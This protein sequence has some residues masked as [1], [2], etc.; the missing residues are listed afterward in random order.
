AQFQKRLKNFCRN[1]DFSY[2][3][4]SYS[5][6]DLYQDTCLKVFK[7]RSTLVAPGNILGERDFW[8][9]LFIVTR[10]QYYNRVR[11]LNRP[12]KSGWSRCDKSVEEL[13]APAAEVD[14][15]K[16]HFLHRFLDFI[17]GYP[18]QRQHA[19]RMWLEGH[20]YRE[21]AAKLDSN[22][23]RSHVTVRS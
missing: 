21:I 10:N 16:Q 15:D 14:Y 3:A 12:Q 5:A 17:R 8:R 1:H 18:K 20:S 19:I 23:R 6:E 4:G 7:Y 13:D 22:E 2:F 9:W 11:Q